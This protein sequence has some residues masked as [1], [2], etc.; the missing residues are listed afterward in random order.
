MTPRIP[1]ND[2]PK[3]ITGEDRFEAAVIAFFAIIL[4]IFILMIAFGTVIYLW[5]VGLINSIVIIGVSS[6]LFAIGRAI[7][8]TILEKDFL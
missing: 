3:K 7:Y 8:Y 1:Y 2:E 4:G 5:K 6:G